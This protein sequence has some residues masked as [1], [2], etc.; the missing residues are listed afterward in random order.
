MER[1]LPEI[2]GNAYELLKEIGAGSA[3]I[4]YSAKHTETGKTRAVK[5]FHLPEGGSLDSI[6]SEFYLLNGLRHPHILPVLDFGVTTC[7][8]PFWVMPLVKLINIAEF[9]RTLTAKIAAEYLKQIL[10]AL[11]YLHVSGIIHGDLKP[12]NILIQ[13]D[14]SSANMK[15]MPGFIVKLT[16]FGMSFLTRSGRGETRGGSFPYMAPECLTRGWMDPRSDLFSVG[17]TLAELL[18]GRVP[19]DSVDEYRRL[20]RPGADSESREYPTEMSKLGHIADQLMEP[21]PNK[22]FLSA[23]DVLKTLAVSAG[24]T[25]GIKSDNNFIVNPAGRGF[26]VGSTFVGRNDIL[27]TLDHAFQDFRGKVSEDPDNCSGQ[28]IIMRGMSGTGFTRIL[29]EWDQKCRLDTVNC[30]YYRAG[31]KEMFEDIVTC[32]KVQELSLQMKALESSI[33]DSFESEKS[34]MPCIVIVDDADLA[35]HFSRSILQNFILNPPGNIL[36]ICVWHMEE[37]ELNPKVIVIDLQALDK[38][39]V[40]KMIRSRF[41]PEPSESLVKFIVSYSG[42]IPA[43]ITRTIDAFFQLGI[44]TFE[45]NAWRQKRLPEIGEKSILEITGPE[46]LQLKSL[47]SEIRKFALELSFLGRQV[48][49]ALVRSVF[50]FSVDELK[51]KLKLLRKKQI[52]VAGA[53]GLEFSSPGFGDIAGQLLSKTQ[54]NELHLK[55]AT[56]L[57][58]NQGNMVDI[59]R[60]FLA[61]GDKKAGVKNLYYGSVKILRNGNIDLALGL[62]SKLQQTIETS[63]DT[64]INAEYKWLIALETG[65]GLVRKGDIERAIVFYES[66]LEATDEPGQQ[67]SVM[68][69]LAMARLRAGETEKALSMLMDA[70]ELA[71]KA[72]QP[73]QQGILQA[74]LGNLYFQ[75]DRLQDAA[76][77]YRAAL[78]QLEKVGNNRVAGAVWNNLGSVKEMLG[79]FDGAF[80]AYTRAFPLKMKLGDR[81]GE[82]VLRHNIGH[83]LVERGRIRAAKAQLEKATLSLK[84]QGETSHLIQFLGNL[85]LAELYE[86]NYRA[87]AVRLEQADP[88]LR[89]IDDQDLLCWLISIKGKL[90]TECGNPEAALQVMQPL[91]DKVFSAKTVGREQGFFIIRYRLAAIQAGQIHDLMQLKIPECPFAEH[92]PLLRSEQLLVD[93]MLSLRTFDFS[94]AKQMALKAASIAKKNNLFFKECHALAILAEILISQHQPMQALDCLTQVIFEKLRK[95]GAQPIFA[96]WTALAAVAYDSLGDRTASEHADAQAGVIIA[97]LIE[98]LPPE[99]DPQQF[100]ARFVSQPA[101][102]KASQRYYVSTSTTKQVQEIEM[103]DRK[104]LTLLLEIS[105]A[106][107]QETDIDALLKRIVD[108]S[109]ELTG[110]ERGFLYLKASV[111][112]DTILVTRNIDKN[113]IFGSKAQIST[114][115]LDEVMRTSRPVMLSDSL[116]D[117]HFRQRQSILA[118]N[119]RTIMCAPISETFSSAGQKPSNMA[120]GVLYVDGTATGR[121]FSDLDREV[122]EALASHAGIGLAN[123]RQRNKLTIENRALKK[124]IRS[125]FGFD[126]LIGTSPAMGKLKT[127]LGK[128]APSAATVLVYGESGTGK[129]L[130]AKTLHYNSPREAEAFLTINCAALAESVLESE[131][132]GVESGVAT[133]VKRRKGLFV[134]A[135]GGTLF[136]DEI[137]DMPLNMQAKILRVLQERRVRPVGATQSVDIDVR[138]ICATNKDLWEETRAGKFRE[139]LLF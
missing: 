75:R 91:R 20:L 33:R 73:A 132:F 124:Q 26:L 57:E 7:N 121:R 127:M 67:S 29:R 28:S 103:E 98:N 58:A 64:E 95:S 4:V 87:A 99:T 120:A 13:G 18:L 71:G 119:L 110:A 49:M 118:H 128:V 111:D 77:T 8:R 76:D 89:E 39:S 46:K 31:K 19:F 96:K 134:Q 5:V 53:E 78:P 115:V 41:V 94:S 21:D 24:N 69:N 27:Q 88:R 114:S 135:D 85:A 56:Y 16:D 2:P 81:L 97:N 137:G 44:I 129:E 68:G 80:T 37:I 72:R 9:Q 35:D 86:G 61:A 54:R 45:K 22:R 83:I 30:R 25:S 107:N 105:K 133:G 122:F 32:F 36:L 38:N 117:E 62:L 12:D 59:G 139:D 66:A 34:D 43:V 102:D 74:Q 126:Q 11:D 51:D 6:E 70:A 93:A 108:H 50:Q 104:K 130:V 138:I 10:H 82:A 14:D 40:Q 23:A 55:A 112:S 106:L 84:E 15:D 113:E 101:P 65:N 136:L 125:H 52:L 131:L 3:G 90:L 47:D 63:S 116:N 100:K 60:H 1:K 48:D 17:V 109:L 42:Q 123:L 92:D 79:D